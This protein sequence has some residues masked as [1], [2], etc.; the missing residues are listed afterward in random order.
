[1]PER[2]RRRNLAIAGKSRRSRA[3][4]IVGIALLVFLLLVLWI[5]LQT[6]GGTST[7]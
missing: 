7:K 4:L 3:P 6:V 5:A 2:V 1:M